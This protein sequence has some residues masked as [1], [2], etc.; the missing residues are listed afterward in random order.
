MLSDGFVGIVTDEQMHQFAGGFEVI[1][2]DE[3]DGTWARIILDVK[4]LIQMRKDPSKTGFFELACTVKGLR[5]E[6]DDLK[7]KKSLTLD[8]KETFMSLRSKLVQVY[9][10]IQDREPQLRKIAGSGKT[11]GHAIIRQ[12]KECLLL[13]VVGQEVEVT[14]PIGTHNGRLRW[15]VTNANLSCVEVYVSEDEGGEVLLKFDML[16]FGAEYMFELLGER[17]SVEEQ[18]SI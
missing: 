8:E 7:E 3:N 16:E 14:S 15:A 2:R 1:L 11:R 9:T 5:E 6:L 17:E 13:Q 18:Y 12:L 10:F 4:T